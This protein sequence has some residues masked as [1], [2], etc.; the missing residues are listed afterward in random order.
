MAATAPSPSPA[1]TLSGLLPG[2]LR[3]RLS[4]RRDVIVLM[5]LTLL[6]KPFGFAVQ[7]LIASSFGARAET[8]AYFIGFFLATVVANM[9]VQV[10]TTLVIPLYFDHAA[11]GDE[12]A[13]L[14]FL[15][16]VFGIFLA[17]LVA[18]ALLLLLAPRWAIA[19]AAPGFQGG[20][21]ALTE[22]M[23]RLMA[24]GTILTGVGGYLSA[25][26]NIRRVFWLPGMVPIL[27]AIVTIGAIL[28]LRNVVGPACLAIGFLAAALLKVAL[29]VGAASRLGLLRAVRPAWR[30]PLVSR[31]LGMTAPV[32]LSALIVQALF[33]VDKMMASHLYEGSVSALSYANTINML[34]LQLFAGT[35][36]TVLFTDLASLVSVGDRPGF[37]RS[38]QQDTRYLLAMIVPFAA[39]AI[40]KSEEIVGILYGRGK[41][42]QTAMRVTAKALVMYSLGLP[43][44]GM[45]MLLA[46]VFHALKAMGARTLIDL[47]WLASN[48]VANLL[49]VGSMGVAGL[50]LGTSIASAVNMGLALVYLRRRHGGVGEGAVLRAFAESLLAGAAMAGVVLAVPAHALGD[51]SASRLARAGALTAVGLVGLAVYAAVLLLVRRVGPRPRA[52]PAPVS[53]R[54]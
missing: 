37:R 6:A 36:V 48:V 34:A 39:L 53:P 31:L 41:F 28:G 23:T 33:M 38:F 32:L 42:D 21:L 51:W 12:R 43:M 18:F 13:T 46:R 1:R 25:T 22:R 7:L 47:A 11:R 45:N 49:L 44:L 9:G 27:Q 2:S 17:P 35:F 52:V 20:T 15:N 29:Q 54:G 16:A 50:A 14:A 30:D 10:F 8:D 5:A 24:V 19:V 40:V 3:R 26:L 4:E